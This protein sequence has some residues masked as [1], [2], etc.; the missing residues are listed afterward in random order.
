[1]KNRIAEL[2]KDRGLR[3]I[4]LARMIGVNPS[5]ITRMVQGHGIESHIGPLCMALQCHPGELWMP[6]P[7]KG[8]LPLTNSQKQVFEMVAGMSPADLE[9]MFQ[10]GDALKKRAKKAGSKH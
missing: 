1:M 6:L 5:T 4:D 8:E 10:I 9:V 2:M 7:H 3:P